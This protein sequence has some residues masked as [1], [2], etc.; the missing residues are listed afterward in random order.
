MENQDKS[1]INVCPT[2]G[3]IQLTP[4][5]RALGRSIPMRL[6]DNPKATQYEFLKDLAREAFWEYF[7]PTPK[8]MEEIAPERML[9]RRLLDWAKESPNWEVNH[10]KTMGSS[11]ISALSGQLLSQ[12]LTTDEVMADLVKKQQEAEQLANEADAL[13]QQAQQDAKNGNS[14]GAQKKSNEAQ[15]KR[16]Q[17]QGVADEINDAMDKVSKS[18]SGKAIRA[19]AVRQATEKAQNT[20]DGLSGWGFETGDMSAV[21]AEEVLSMLAKHNGIM[22]KITPLVGRVKGIAL[23]AKAKEIKKV[24]IVVRDGYTQKMQNIFPSEMALLRPDANAFIRATKMG[25]FCERGLLGM[26]EGS[27]SITEGSLVVAVDD[28]GSMGGWREITAKALALGIAKAAQTTGQTYKA[29]RFSTACDDF[30]VVSDQSTPQETLEW[31]I[32][33]Q[34]GGTDF[35]FALNTS[36]DL[37]MSMGAHAEDADIVI[38]TDG[39]CELSQATAKR[40]RDMRDLMGTRLIYLQVGN[41]GQRYETLAKIAN[42]ILVIADGENMDNIAERLTEAMAREPEK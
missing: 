32:Q 26:V 38:I 42:A 40:Y 4:A 13:D 17:A 15:K 31:C 37:V 23:S 33:S 20:I 16:E 35:D 28:S 39:E 29:F 34:G 5:Q 18:P 21:E 14:G 7:M 9:N 22:D 10:I 1:I 41:A 19:H 36:M 6:V 30:P 2:K 8:P 12:Q 27:E 25:E 3:T 11:L 24:G